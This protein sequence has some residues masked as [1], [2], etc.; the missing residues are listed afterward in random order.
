MIINDVVVR[1]TDYLE[2]R[3]SAIR[4]KGNYFAVAAT[5]LL[6]RFDANT[7]KEML[8]TTGHL[9]TTGLSPVC[10]TLK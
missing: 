5:V 2:M 1:I 10:A 6:A 7:P 9:K 3:P 8:G 4:T